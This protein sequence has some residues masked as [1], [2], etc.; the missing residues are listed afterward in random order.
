MASESTS[1]ETIEQSSLVPKKG[2]HLNPGVAALCTFGIWLLLAVSNLIFARDSP[3]FLSINPSPWILLPLVIGVLFGY[4]WAIIAVVISIGAIFGLR[5]TAPNVDEAFP[6]FLC[7]SLLVVG[8]LTASVRETFVRFVR[9]RQSDTSEM[10]TE[11][12]RLRTDLKLTDN[13][14]QNLQSELVKQNIE[15]LGLYLSLET[16]FSSEPY[17]TLDAGFLHLIQRDCHM[18]TAAI[19]EGTPNGLNLV[20]KN[21]EDAGLPDSIKPGQIPMVDAAFAYKQMI[22]HRWFWEARPADAAA[23]LD[24]KLIAVIPYLC[25][26]GSWRLLLV[27]RMAFEGISWENFQTIQAAFCWFERGKSFMSDAPTDLSSSPASNDGV[28]SV[29]EFKQKLAQERIITEGLDIDSRLIVF[30]PMKKLTAEMRDQM[31]STLVER[32]NYNENVTLIPADTGTYAYILMATG[33]GQSSAKAR[34]EALIPKLPDIGIKYYI[35]TPH[36]KNLDALC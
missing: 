7:W 25:D 3:G 21:R 5:S 18:V 20:L 36:D 11:I 2:K 12:K 19:Y 15:P 16:L 28:L 23:T 4:V 27:E 35:L 13:Y 6:F 22:T 31:T 24:D 9:R 17:S 8:A 34:A 14:R 10:E 32:A 30:T 26:D 1:P 33:L 29:E